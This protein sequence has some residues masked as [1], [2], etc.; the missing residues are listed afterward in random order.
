M[1]LQE[2][3]RLL[4]LWDIMNLFDVYSLSHI[5]HKFTQCQVPLLMQKMSG[6]GNMDMTPATRQRA[7]QALAEAELFFKVV[8]IKEGKDAVQS[9]KEQWEGPLLDVSSANEIIRRLQWD[10]VRAMENRLFLRVEDD[11]LEMIPRLQGNVAHSGIVG[12]FGDAV[13]NAF[14]SAFSDIIE[15][16]NCLAAECNTAA[17][18]HLMRIAEVGLRAVAKDRNA[19]FA[20]KPIDQQEW[21]TILAFLDGRV[22]ELRLD[23]GSKWP[24]P[25]L[26]DI[27][28]RFYA[29]VVSELRAFNEAWRRHL[30]HAREDGI[31]DRDYANS[32]F[33]HVKTFM[34][35]LA[36]KI[37]EN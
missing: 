17:V 32:V 3:P 35:K 21:G 8:E 30:S 37:G 23:P 33:K 34:Q 26:K 24:N 13:K 19:N 28:I 20:N 14:P 1:P 4:S 12:L 7:E 6:Q 11:R 10:I 9:A 18:F 15:T 5:L 31:Y 27:Q 22:Q 29:E 16:G 2:F 36:E 25:G